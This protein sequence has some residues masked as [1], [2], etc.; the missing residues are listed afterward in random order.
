MSASD[1]EQ[2]EVE[3]DASTMLRHSTAR[4][5]AAQ[6]LEL[7]RLM[8]L[9]RKVEDRL[10]NLYRQG[11]VVGGLYSSL[12]QEAISVAS[13]YAMRPGDKIAP[14]IRNLGAMLVKGVQPR[15]VFC[16]YMAR[17]D[18]PSFGRD[19]NLHFGDLDRDIVAP[20]SMLGA[21][22]PIM[23]GMALA[24]QMR[25]E[26][27]VMLTYIGDGGASTGDFHEGLNLAAVWK[28]PFI[29]ICENNG[30][31]YSTPTSGQMANTRMV[32][33]AKA[34]GV[35]GERIDGNDAIAVYHAVSRA[36]KRAR[37]NGGPTLIEAMTFRMKGHAEHDDA[38][39]VPPAL[40]E[41]WRAKDPIARMRRYL[42]DEPLATAEELDALV[43]PMDADIDADTDF[44]LASPFPDAAIAS[45]GVFAD[46]DDPR[47]ARGAS[48]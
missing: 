15:E 44:A 38:G 31:A 23:A 19:C 43:L 30:Y 34:Y 40:V 48:T 8:V 17:A 18:G 20:I 47:A 33:R 37:N 27:N 16:Q 1:G 14:M 32:D 29:L 42:L 13:A 35:R 12:G 41:E 7:Y 25:G 28:L 9:N 5:S 6:L 39:Y 2:R 11:Q 26:K 46:G 10:G 3:V 4:L 36:A 24:S 21:M 45:G 22:I